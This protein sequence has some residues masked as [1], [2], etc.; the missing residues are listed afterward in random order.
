MRGV[1][2]ENWKKLREELRAN[3]RLRIGTIAIVG[4]LA[5]YAALVLNDWRRALAE[6]YRE[7]TLQLYKVAALAGQSQWPNRAQDAASIRRALQARIPPASSTGLAQAEMQTWM[8]QLLRGFGQQL[9]TE[10]EPPTRVDASQGIWKIPM[11]VRGPLSSR[12]LL[13]ILSKIEGAERMFVV[14][15][16]TIDNQPRPIVNMTVSAYYRIGARGEAANAAP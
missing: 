7:R 2:A 5:L 12:Q 3:R 16:I 1:L 15:K 4:I 10:S 6:E 9:T 11:A 8:N 14:E 13:E